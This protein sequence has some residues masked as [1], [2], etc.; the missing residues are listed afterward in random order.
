M[1]YGCEATLL[2][3]IEWFLALKDIIK[4]VKTWGVSFK[5]D[6][7]DKYTLVAATLFIGIVYAS[8]PDTKHAGGIF[9]RW[10][11]WFITLGATPFFGGYRLGDH[12]CCRNLALA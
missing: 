1:E 10:P 7:R 3:Q 6:F 12:D 2:L 5:G 9:Y 8:W 11:D 4:S